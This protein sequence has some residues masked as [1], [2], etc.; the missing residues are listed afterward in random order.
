MS[1][2]MAWEVAAAN[3]REARR[4]AAKPVRPVRNRR[5]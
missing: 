1:S 5:R 3:E 2:L 4:L